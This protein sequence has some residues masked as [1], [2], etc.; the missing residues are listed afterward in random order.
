MSAVVPAD[1]P[2]R[3]LSA[4]F[5]RAA[6]PGPATLQASVLG[7]GR[8]ATHC[9]ARL[10]QG[11]PA[12]PAVRLVVLG[13]FGARRDSAISFAPEP[14]PGLPPPD[15][16]PEMPY[17]EGL[18][19]SFIRH[20]ALRWGHGA[21]PYSGSPVA[22]LGGWVRFRDASGPDGG[23][24]MLDAAWI[25]GLLDAWPPPVLPRLTTPAPASTA[26]LW[27]QLSEAAH[28]PRSADA[29]F[30]FRSRSTHADAGWADY[31]ATLWSEDGVQL[32]TMRQLTAVFA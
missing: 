23:P 24:A 3:S 19:P 12:D 7:G 8:S 26:A 22:D 13:T 11:D 27:V 2:L 15:S 20:V 31:S 4:S 9:E 17:I 10:L 14:G 5:V 16:L 28:E 21:P 6:A 18:T 25:V 29:W 32:A 1:R 30:A